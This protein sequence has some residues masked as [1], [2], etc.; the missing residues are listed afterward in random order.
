MIDIKPLKIKAT[1]MW[2]FLTEKNEMSNAYQVD[3]CDLSQAAINALSDM[4]IE[5]KHKEEK[6]FY[7]TC[8][9]K[10]FPID[11]QYSDGE[12]LREGVRLGNG[13]KVTA[14][15]SPYQWTFKNKKGVSASCKKLIINELIEYK[16]N[17]NDDDA[18]DIDGAGAKDPE[19]EA[20]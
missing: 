2:A 13:S 5:A 12:R 1:V 17:S 15:V 20:L 4:G 10:N 3:L 7:I 11:A 14:I 16:K 8:K 9:S 6:G 19:A 18:L